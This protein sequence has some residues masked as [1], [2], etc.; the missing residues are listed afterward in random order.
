MIVSF[1]DKATEAIFDGRN[2]AAAR[3][4]L[5]QQLHSNAV[6]KLEVLNASVSLESVGKVPANH[7]EKLKGARKGLHS[8]RINDQYR[9][10]FRWTDQGPA[11]LEIVDYH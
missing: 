8:I 6:R 2:T 11:D 3:R 5:P 9:I 4:T 1:R 10:C 7:L